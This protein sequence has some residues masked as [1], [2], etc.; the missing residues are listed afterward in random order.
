MKKLT[1]SILSVVIAVTA[2]ATL[3]S[4]ATADLSIYDAVIAADNAG[5]L[6]YE[7]ISTTSVSFDGTDGAAFDFGAIS[8]S[9]TIEFIVSGDAVAGGRNGFLGVG[10]NATFSL[11]YEQWD[12]TGQLGF[13]H[14]GVADYTLDPPVTSPA[15][16]THVT[17][18][19]DDPS[20]TM[21]IYL[22][23][24]LGGTATAPDFEMP[25]GLG[26]LGNNAGLTEGM[27]GTIDRVTVY[28]S[29]LD[30]AIVDGHAQAWLIPEPTAIVLLGLA[31]FP[32]IATF[33][34]RKRTA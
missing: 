14:G 4:P 24:V 28:N 15:T 31:A 2:S 7:A 17:Y 21:T 19:W 23:G 9:S 32:L 1:L 8:G 5:G 6:S 13:T 26:S 18:Q 27:L 12:D 25:T 11:R 29:V 10:S 22:D 20:S 3:I 33:R 16:P 34:R 30:P